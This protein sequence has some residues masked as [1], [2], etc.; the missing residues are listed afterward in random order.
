VGGVKIGGLAALKSMDALWTVSEVADTLRV[1]PA[2][3]Y[4]WVRSGQLPAVRLGSRLIRIRDH[5]LLAFTAPHTD[6]SSLSP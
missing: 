2:T 5:D 6:R 1:S 4:G 3:V